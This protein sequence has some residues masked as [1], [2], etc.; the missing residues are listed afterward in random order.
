[1]APANGNMGR[2][3]SRAV[4]RVP[5]YDRSHSRRLGQLALHREGIVQPVD[6]HN[7]DVIQP[8]AIQ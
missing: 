4:D 7:E 5:T 3:S 6:E 8:R 1:M 2:S